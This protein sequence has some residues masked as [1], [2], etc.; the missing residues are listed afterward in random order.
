LIPGLLV[1]SLEVGVQTKR[2]F[3]AAC[4]LSCL[5]ALALSGAA[6][7]DW[8]RVGPDQVSF[9]REHT[10]KKFVAWGL[11][12]DRDA[13]GRLI[14]DYWES[15]WSTVE[16][17]FREMKDLGAN[18][19]RVHLQLGR[20]MATSQ[21]PNT[22]SLARLTQLR[23]LAERT[24]FYL[25]L[26]G[27]GCYH[28]KDVPKW[29]DSLPEAER[30][31]VQARFWE[32]VSQTCAGSPVVFCYDLMNEPILPG[33]KPETEWL[34]GELGGKYYVQRISLNL[35]GRTQPAV[36]KA[37][38]RELVA[39]IRAHDKRHL[40]TIGEIPWATVFPGAKSMFHS[41]DVG[42]G[43]DFVSVHF[44]PERNQVEKALQAL[45]AYEIGKPLVIEEMFPLKCSVE[46][47]DAF[48]MGSRATTD[49]WLGFYWGKT[50]DQYRKSNGGASEA[51]TRDWLEYFQRKASVMKT[52]D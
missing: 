41:K 46:E 12:Y 6:S 50:I 33:D 48:V 20:F 36:A 51:I 4:I 21:Q 30:W 35:A 1:N 19:V 23:G 14:E 45:S 11:N 42:A 15:E 28:K 22:N 32:A 8:I 9:V 29:Y 10:G 47:L 52:S 27:L 38:V 16:A 39:A 7:L 25:D 31:R 40:I 13:G 44:Y 18:V 2:F 26:T 43:L 37:W 24:G 3:F 34:T 5:S 49:G 17:D